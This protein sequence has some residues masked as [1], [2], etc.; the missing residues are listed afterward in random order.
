M[1]SYN[2]SII[3]T[4]IPPKEEE[5][6][7]MQNQPPYL[8]KKSSSNSLSGTQGQNMIGVNCSASFLQQ[9]RVQSLGMG[10]KFPDPSLSSL[11]QSYK[12]EAPVPRK[13]L[14]PPHLRPAFVPQSYQAQSSAPYSQTL[15]IRYPDFP[16]GQGIRRM[17]FNPGLVHH[18]AFPPERPPLFK[19]Q[20][21]VF[22]FP[23]FLQFDQRIPK[24]VQE[25]LNCIQKAI[26]EGSKHVSSNSCKEREEGEAFDVAQ[27][28]SQAREPQTILLPTATSKSI[29]NATTPAKYTVHTELESRDQSGELHDWGKDLLNSP[30]A[31][32][33]HPGATL[34][35]TIKVARQ[36]AQLKAQQKLIA[37]QFHNFYGPNLPTTLPQPQPQPQPLRQ[38]QH[39][40]PPHIKNLQ[41]QFQ[42]NHNLHY[43]HA[44]NRF[45]PY[46]IFDEYYQS[47]TGNVL[48]VPKGKRKYTKIG[49]KRKKSPKVGEKRKKSPKLKQPKKRAI[50]KTASNP[51]TTSLSV[52]PS[53]LSL[54]ALAAEM[55]CT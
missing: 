37:S 38:F 26:M 51:I 42:G 14:F 28:T 35:Q 36:K 52:A 16:Y 11:R 18:S 15:G 43:I 33:F 9:K 23:K 25:Q 7:K 1:L 47:Q 10:L 2:S 20:K 53:Q 45:Y 32:P 22:S 40:F 5:T 49:E 29:G 34:L 8:K 3:N 30:K 27:I 39:P 13:L 4:E 24:S 48:S 46:P 41:N 55:S 19:S 54:L 44:P 21:S 17:D 50:A 6:Q 31:K 12:T